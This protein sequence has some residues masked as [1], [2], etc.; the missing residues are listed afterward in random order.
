M[1][2]K[3]KGNPP[4]SSGWIKIATVDANG[5]KWG[6]YA[7]EDKQSFGWRPIKVCVDGKITIKANYWT[8][9]NSETMILSRSRDA[10]L[11]AK[12]R[13]ELYDK[14]MGALVDWY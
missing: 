8:S 5:S 7:N 6:I 13:P 2:Q 11:M 10:G 12:N 1:G 9:F 4:D 3:F 14:V